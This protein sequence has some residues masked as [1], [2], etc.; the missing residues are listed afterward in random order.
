MNRNTLVILVISLFFVTTPLL[1]QEASTTP[2]EDRRAEIEERQTQRKAEVESR[3]AEL[4]EKREAKRVE[5]TE[6]R[7]ERIRA[8]AEK[9]IARFMAAVERLEKLSERI[10]ERIAKMEEGGVDLSEAKLLLEDANA[11]IREARAQID[12]AINTIP[13]ILQNDNPKEIFES[14]REALN[15]AKESIKSAHRG[16]VEVI[17]NIKNSV[18][19]SEE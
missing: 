10:T 17:K 8:Y 5:L 4:E 15:K 12:F 9:V 7:K 3:K 2:R 14:V 1:A 6:K 11:E 19:Q 13:S 18:S 16:L